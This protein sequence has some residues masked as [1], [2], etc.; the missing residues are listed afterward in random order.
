[1][2]PEQ[3]SALSLLFLQRADKDVCLHTKA[4]RQEAQRL[5]QTANP[6]APLPSMHWLKLFVERHPELGQGKQ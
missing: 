6:D 5:A 4:I 3:E 2:T 1:M